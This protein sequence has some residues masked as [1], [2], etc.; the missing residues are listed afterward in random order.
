MG[1][2]PPTALRACTRLL[3]Y[4]WNSSHTRIKEMTVWYLLW[5]SATAALNDLRLVVAIL[6][7]LVALRV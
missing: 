3:P 5:E 1:S 6:I 2:H 4:E 7:V